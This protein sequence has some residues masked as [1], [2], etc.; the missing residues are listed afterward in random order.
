[1]STVPLALYAHFPWC[2]RKCPYCDFNSHVRD[3]ALP[4]AAYVDALLR[5]LDAEC[6]TLASPRP[7][8]SLFLGGGTPSLF[9]P[10]AIA[11]LLAGIRAR[12]AFTDDVE[13]TLEANPGTVDERHFAGYRDAGVNRLSIGV[14]SFDDAKLQALGRI[15]DGARASLA[16]GNAQRAG[17]TR[18]N[19]DLMHGL[20]GQDDDAA[21]ADL[22]RALD[23]GVEH[24][25]WY[26]LT[27]EPNTVF[28]RRP[29]VLPD[30]DAL[31][32]IEDAGFAVLEAAGFSRYEV[33]AWSRPGCA[34]RHNLNYWRFGDYLAIGAGAHGKVSTRDHDSTLHIERYQKSRTPD[35]YLA[36]QARRQPRALSADDR[37]LEFMLNALRLRDGVP[38]Q[39]FVDHTGLGLESVTPTLAALRAR[40]LLREDRIGTTDLGY[41]HLDSVVAEFLPDEEVGEAG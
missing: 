25:S 37:V 38:A 19:V 1:L 8:V 30:D 40:G 36:D 31:G 16:I 24:I 3:G 41:R 29:P 20:P 21:V 10:S 6:A 7:L 14:Q 33:S 4:E 28:H 35:D 22:Q 34:S 12:L 17:F 39:A 2:A 23:A 13:I 27:I 9:S 26:Q 15:H 18:I 5:D 32:S 11:R